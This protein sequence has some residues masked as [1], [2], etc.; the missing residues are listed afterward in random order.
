MKC[1]SSCSG[2]Y[3][4]NKTRHCQYCGVNCDAGLD[5][6]TNLT[7]INGSANVFVNFNSD[8]TINGDLYSTFEV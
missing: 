6:D 7:Y 1:V 5:F 4:P 3:R 8:I 2:G